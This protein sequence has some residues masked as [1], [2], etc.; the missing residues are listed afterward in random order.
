MIDFI[1]K[2]RLTKV[3]DCNAHSESLCP[4][5][6]GNQSFKYLPAQSVGVERK[7]SES[8]HVRE[9]VPF[10]QE[11]SPVSAPAPKTAHRIADSAPTHHRRTSLN[12]SRTDHSS[13]FSFYC[14]TD[15]LLPTNAASFAPASS[16]TVQRNTRVFLKL[17]L[18]KRSKS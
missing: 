18:N 8:F 6:S 3:K 2:T 17:L 10:L 14:L 1:R 16:W 5:N 7:V 15:A 12:D 13:L 4:S 9:L 11:S